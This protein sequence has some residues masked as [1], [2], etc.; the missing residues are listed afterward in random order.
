ML[1]SQQKPFSDI[2]SYL[3]GE[4]KVFLVGCHGCAEASGT[5]GPKQVR[6]MK[7]RLE[8]EGKTVT[9]WTVVD[10][11]CQRALVKTGLKPFEPQIMAADSLLILCCGIGVQTTA[12][13]VSKVVHPA[14]DTISLG[15]AYGE[16]RGSERCKE[17]GECF[18]DLT[19][20]I[21]PLTAC[22]KGLL[23]GPC[24]GPRDGRCEVEPDV[25]PCGWIL[26]YER[27]KE[28]GRLDR[29]RNAPIQVK[30]FAKMEPPREL[31]K[32]ARYSL[33]QRS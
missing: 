26:I 2:L 21:C 24:G 6:E 33:D 1:V 30:D 10:F 14:C 23:N 28:L 31:R 16:W 22:S 13:V 15:G 5:G 4:Q 7:D 18:L 25:R 8:K 32:S 20:G 12:A 3:E 9:G 27:L 19:G 17:C 11:L 29:L